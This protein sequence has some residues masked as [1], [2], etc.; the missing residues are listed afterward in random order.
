M[1]KV[2]VITT[3]Y[4][5]SETM[6][7]S[8]ES[9]LNQDYKNWELILFDDGSEDGTQEIAKKFAKDFPSKVFYFEHAGN[10]N[11]GIAYTRNRAIEKSTGDIIAFIDQDDIWLPNRLSH[12]INI[13]DEYPECAMVWGPAEYWYQ[14]RSF[15][16]QVGAD[17]QG[18]KNGIYSPPFF[19]ETFLRNLGGTPCPTGT[20]VNKKNFYTVNGFEEEIKGPDD[21][22]LWIKL[23]NKF[24]VYYD[25]LVLFKYR[26]HANS[27][28]SK[29]KK[30]GK[31][32][33]W[34]LVFYKWI[35]D[36]LKN[37]DLK[38]KKELIKDSEF[39]Y[40]IN[41]KKTLNK[42]G[43]FKSRKEIINKLNSYPELKKKY[44]GDFLL[45]LILPFDIAT[46]VS[47]K[48]RFDWFKN[49]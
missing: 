15:K 46:K 33:E 43:Y 42:F 38:F 26:K 45:D 47:S 35:I 8:I 27:F 24:Q 7:E 21:I 28:L 5:G 20:M 41:L 48:I 39:S 49:Y 25:D 4:N 3:V 23:S 17:K 29:S 13:F 14:D 37:T 22:I 40:Y 44:R 18:L 34:N 19:V 31:F 10:K 12:H 9:I 30:S 2:S 11:F 16:Q 1:K 6:I 32:Y 36:F